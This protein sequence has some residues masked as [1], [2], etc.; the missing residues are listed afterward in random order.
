MV[1]PD[2]IHPTP[3][4]GSPINPKLNSPITIDCQTLRCL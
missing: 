1:Q 2:V 3:Y 4:V